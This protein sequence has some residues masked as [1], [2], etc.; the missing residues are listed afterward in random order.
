MK[1]NFGEMKI[2]KKIINPNNNKIIKFLKM[3]KI[4][5]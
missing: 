1:N 5:K 4:S 2:K 3:N